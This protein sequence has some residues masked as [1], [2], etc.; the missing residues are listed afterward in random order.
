MKIGDRVVCIK[1]HSQGVVVKDREYSIY[2]KR[3]CKCG[4]VSFDVGIENLHNLNQCPCKQ[5]YQSDAHLVSSK[6]FAPL[7]PFKSNSISKALAKEA[8]KEIVEQ[9][10]LEVC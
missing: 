9:E 10:T 7:Q 5:I 2:A 6:L 4:D 1:T 3:V 8:M